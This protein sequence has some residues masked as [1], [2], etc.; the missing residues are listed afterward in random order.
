[1]REVGLGGIAILKRIFQKSNAKMWTELKI[2]KWDLVV[3]FCEQNVDCPG[4]VKAEKLSAFKK[5]SC[6]VD[7]IS[8]NI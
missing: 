3:K 4:S 7:L 6:T 1:M 2:S 8:S 5:M